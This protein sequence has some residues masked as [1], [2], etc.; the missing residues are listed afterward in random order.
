M[1]VSFCRSCNAPLAAG[2]QFCEQCGADQAKPAP[3]N[4]AS[5]MRPCPNCGATN[6][7]FAFR[8]ARCNQPFSMPTASTTDTPRPLTVSDIAIGVF[9]GMVAFSLFSALIWLGF[10]LLIARG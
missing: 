7:A 10:V 9:L 5:S 8:C 1:A 6:P 2:A 4:S 3:A